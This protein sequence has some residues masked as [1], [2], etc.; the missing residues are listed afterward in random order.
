VAIFSFV[1]AAGW[2]MSWSK[3]EAQPS[4]SAGFNINSTASF[5]QPLAPYGTW[6]DLSAYGRCWRPMGV[7]EG[8]RPYTVGDWDWTDAGWYWASNEPW[9]WACYHYGSW[10]FDPAYG[11]LWIPGTEWAPAWVVWR[12]APDYIGWAPCGP[13][14][15]IVVDSY[16]SFVD[17]HRFHD[18]LGP[19]VLL[20][21]DRAV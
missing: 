11:W 13:R 5:Y 15:R 14:G 8:W 7:A 19:R 16:F 20:Y 2:D 1:L 17:V 18:H 21:N 9:A 10:V 3:A 6:L 4:F 12:E